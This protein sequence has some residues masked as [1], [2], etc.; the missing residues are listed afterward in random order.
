LKILYVAQSFHPKVGGAEN[1]IDSIAKTMVEKGHEVFVLAPLY[2]NCKKF[3][4]FN[5]YQIIRTDFRDNLKKGIF[6]HLRVLNFLPGFHKII[7]EVKPDIVHFQYTNP[8]GVLFFIN[9]LKKIKSF[10]SAHGNDILFF[11]NDWFARHLLKS[12]M[13]NMNGIITVSDNS[14][15]LLVDVGGNP[16]NIHVVYNGTDFYKFQ[17]TAKQVRKHDKNMW[18]ILTVCRLVERKGVDVLIKAF[19]KVLKKT[20]AELYIVG[21]GP[22]KSELKDIANTLG[23]KNKV[24]FLGKVS[25]EQL[26]EQYNL[27]DVFVLVSRVMDEANEI[28]G[29]G[30]SIVEAMAFGKPV[31][32]STTGGIPSAIKGDWGYLVDPLDYNEL[33]NKLMFL[34]KNPKIADEMG[35]KG[36]IAVENIYNWDVISD[37]ISKIYNEN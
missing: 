14:K 29:F 7:Q 17:P 13:K 19:S 30:I 6:Y 31:I 26:I 8:F 18:R 35:K 16:K 21:E 34:R 27:C 33:A 10:A 3:E 36:R 32:G 5:N 22:M 28:E 24:H 15:K 25:E 11:G 9:K 1:Y 20:P 2:P 4:K 23:I 37:K 12:V